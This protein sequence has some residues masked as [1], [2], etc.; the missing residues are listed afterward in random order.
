[1][2][3]SLTSDSALRRYD[4]R[5][6]TAVPE[7]RVALALLV[8]V[9]AA[10]WPGGR[11]EA[12]LTLGFEP[13]ASGLHSPVGVTHAG[14]GSRRLFILEQAGRILIHDGSR[15]LPSAFL[16]VSALVSCCDERGLL[17]LAFH[18]DYVANGLFYVDYTNTAGDTVIARYHVSADANVADPTSAQILLTIAQPFANHNGGQLAFGPAGFLYIGMGDRGGAGGP[19][20][21]APKIREL[22]GQKLR[23]DV[24]GA[25]PYAI[26]AT[27]PFRS[28]PGARPEIWA[29]GLRNPWRF[30]FD[31]QFG[32]PF[33][34]DVGQD[35]GGGG[36]FP[37][38]PRAGGVNDG[39][40]LM[41]GGPAY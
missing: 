28:T 37:P 30:R 1:M 6:G 31:R 21:R 36:G 41:G 23:L 2:T 39:G 12:Q 3:F 16:D 9:A 17:G 13:V 25:A 20:Q 19:R 7:G 24:N 22:P 38:A 11:A 32:D 4:R 15:V 26:P 29:Y 40:G 14:D 18:P 35:T 10:V 34:A 33:I 27:N 5:V 8:A